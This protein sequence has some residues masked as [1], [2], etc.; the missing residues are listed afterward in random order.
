MS[1]AFDTVNIHKLTLTSIPNIIIKSIVNNT[2]GRQACTQFN[3][4]VSKP[5]QINIGVPQDGVL[6][7]TLFNTFT[8][9]ISAPQKTYKLQFMPMT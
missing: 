1:K 5:K 4:T 3:G 8:S 6:S 7:L 2:K 9:D